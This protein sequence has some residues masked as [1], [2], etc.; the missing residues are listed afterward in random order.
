MNAHDTAAVVVAVVACAFDL[1]SRRIP[2]VL[3]FGA[4]AAA[5]VA[6]ASTGGSGGL[7]SCSAGWL[8]G[9]ALWLPLYALGGMGAGDVK[10]LAAIGAWLGPEDVFHAAL[11]A[12]IAGGVLA[13]VVAYARGCIRQTYWNVQLLIL[14]WRVAGFSPQAQLT[15][16]TATSPRL[17]YA[18]PI[19]AGT[20]GAI[21][22]R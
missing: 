2:N 11:Y 5:L 19:L 16:E 9:T 7:A 4:A 1:H 6:S 20:V 17:A 22:L 18:V 10:L 3:T 8:L 13:L 15:L 21:W 14:H 12:G